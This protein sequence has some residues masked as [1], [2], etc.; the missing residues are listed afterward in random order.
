MTAFDRIERR[1]PERLADL[2]SA[3]VPDYFDDMLRQ[4]AGTRQ[5]PA[6]S[7]LQRWLPLDTTF[8][9]GSGR[10]RPLA[11]LA[12][13]VIVGLLLAAALLAFV[14]ARQHHIPAPFGPAANGSLY[15]T[16]ANGDAFMADSTGLNP[17]A[18]SSAK[19]TDG[20]LPFRSG[21]QVAILRKL[22]GGEQIFV[23]AK[24]GSNSRPLAGTWL[25]FSEIDTS[26]TGA[27][28][29]IVSEVKGVP[30]I[31]ILQ[32]D[33][34]GATTLSLGLAVQNLW[35]QPD[36]SFVFRGD[37]R[38]Q[39]GAMTYGLYSVQA[40]GTG[41]RPI[42]P[43]M[44]LDGD[45]IGMSPS[46]DGRT[47]VYHR[48]VDAPFEHG[49]LHLIN[50]ARSQDTVLQV[51]GTV[52]SDEFEEATFSPDGASILFK[53]FTADGN[54][55]LAVVPAAGGTAVRIGPA[56]PYNVSP[57]PLFSPDGT[58]VIA[59]YPGLNETWL[60]DPTGKGADHPFLG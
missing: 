5:R 51:A 3:R 44:S 1:L 11:G 9:L 10:A 54:V 45:F 53:W 32:A 33:G 36:G 59:W 30:S 16:A 15:Y 47:L 55:R 56:V 49:R 38:N 46:P 22:S 43:A 42:L 19:G 50:V 24:D 28:V 34:S 18:I 29:A 52:D 60:L 7:S 57:H 21:D 40:D 17:V 35:Y 13:L 4:T 58:S 48:W 25:N 31:S 6:W 12:I 37:G 26:P 8:P 27:Q 2:A 39:A 23:A 20:V 41:L 14:G